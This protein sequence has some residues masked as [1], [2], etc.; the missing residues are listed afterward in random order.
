MKNNNNNNNNNIDPPQGEDH[1]MDDDQVQDK[2][3]SSQEEVNLQD[4]AEIEQAIKKHPAFLDL[5]QKN[6]LLLAQIDTSKKVEDLQQRHETLMTGKNADESV[7]QPKVVDLFTQPIKI[8]SCSEGQDPQQIS[9]ARTSLP[10]NETAC[11]SV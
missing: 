5:M 4:E 7:P 6:A 3:A 8:T 9:L 1:L 2:D 11:Y 10:R